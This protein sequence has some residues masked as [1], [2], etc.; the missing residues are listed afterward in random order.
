MGYLTSPMTDRSL[1]DTCTTPS[2]DHF[3]STAPEWIPH[4]MAAKDTM[5]SNGADT[6]A[7]APISAAGEGDNRNLGTVS[8][9][10]PLI[11]PGSYT[12]QNG[13]LTLDTIMDLNYEDTSSVTFGIVMEEDEVDAFRVS[14][15][16]RPI[17]PGSRF[18][19]TK[20][21]T[22]VLEPIPALRMVVQPLMP[23][24]TSMLRR[25]RLLSLHPQ[26]TRKGTPPP[27]I[28]R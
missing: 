16:Y 6:P 5:D 21:S 13:D 7:V 19:R 25:Y 2:S 26:W 11:T 14:T 23:S 18:L 10:R 9:T 27:T 3:N 12:K 24:W 17:T 1:E 4:D 28:G 20:P 8:T 15:T 22:V